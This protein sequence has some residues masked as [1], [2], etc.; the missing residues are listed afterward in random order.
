[1]TKKQ[2]EKVID[3]L[4][5]KETVK[6]ILTLLNGETLEDAK[7]ILDAVSVVLKSGLVDADSLKDVVDDLT[8]E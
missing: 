4:G 5:C 6:Q 2:A 7:N 3:E 1:M 8:A